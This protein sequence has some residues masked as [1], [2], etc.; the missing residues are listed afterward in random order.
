M[1]EKTTTDPKVPG[2]ETNTA[3][4]G[5]CGGEASAESKRAATE[6]DHEHGK[7]AV[8]SKAAESSCCCGSKDG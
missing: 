8:P 3:K 4:H 5:C 6:T 2:N 1:T 7:H